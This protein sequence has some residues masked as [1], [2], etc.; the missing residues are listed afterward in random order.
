MPASHDARAVPASALAA[1]EKA[2]KHK[3]LLLLSGCAPVTRRPA[4]AALAERLQKILWFRLLRLPN[5]S[6]GD[7]DSRRTSKIV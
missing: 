7:Q 5:M 6:L 1:V 4:A 3:S 2:C